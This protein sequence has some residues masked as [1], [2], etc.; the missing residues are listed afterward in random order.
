MI[1]IK[2][3]YYHKDG[4]INYWSRDFMEI[5][6]YDANTDDLKL[7]FELMQGAFSK[8]LLVEEDNMLIEV[9]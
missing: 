6:S 9:I 1:G 5:I 7:D 4:S 2:E 8:P 3:V